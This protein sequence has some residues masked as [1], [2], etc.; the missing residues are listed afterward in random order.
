M[1]EDIDLKKKLDKDA[2]EDELEGLQTRLF[3]LH[4]ALWVKEIPSVI[5]FEGWD[6]AGK[7]TA[8]NVVTEILDP[9]GFKLYPI[10]APRYDEN[11][12]HWLYRFWLKVPRRGEL[13]IFDRSWYRRV[14][15]ARLEK[16][17]GKAE[18]RSAYQ[19]IVDFEKMLTDDGT[20][21]CKFFL[22]ISAKEQRKRFDKLEADPFSKWQVTKL[23]WIQHEKY[24]EYWAAYNEMFAK[25]NTPNAPWTI[26][27]STSR[28]YAQAQIFK[29]LIEQMA[30]RLG[31]Q[32]PADPTPK[33]KK[34]AS[35]TAKKSPKTNPQ[36]EA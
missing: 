2:F 20:L 22:H 9:R 30:A 1:L 35:K 31:E 36:G 27:P 13:V 15:D 5:V 7:G 28:H 12:R 34:A 24:D 19:D 33:V 21:L 14:T 32:A 10:Q 11:L 3:D 8:I 18:W 25:T 23:D 4:H 17:V 26:I 6:A 29:T 16:E